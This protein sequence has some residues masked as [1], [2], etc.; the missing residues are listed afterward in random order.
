LSGHIRDILLFIYMTKPTSS[1]ERRSCV[2]PLFS[3][4]I[5]KK[6]QE[7]E[8]KRENMRM[9]LIT[10]TTKRKDYNMRKIL[11]SIL[12][13]WIDF[14]RNLF[15]LFRKNRKATNLLANTS[16]TTSAAQH[17]RCYSQSISPPYSVLSFS[18][19]DILFRLIEDFVGQVEAVQKNC[20]RQVR[21]MKIR[22][23]KVFLFQ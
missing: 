16:L 9:T 23:L 7:E 5:Q 21:M 15:F 3:H 18:T 4:W 14:D 17:C 22:I 20:S 19:V 13:A 6:K 10:H 12:F 1:F 8:K 11:N 2:D